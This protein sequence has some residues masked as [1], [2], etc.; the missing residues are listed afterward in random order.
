MPRSSRIRSITL[1]GGSPFYDAFFAQDDAVRQSYD[2]GA[3]VAEFCS[4]L[5][6]RHLTRMATGTLPGV[7]KTGR[8]IFP[9]F[10]SF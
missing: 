10:G 8:P 5:P 3:L 9:R 7:F 4:K 6:R 1:M 2:E